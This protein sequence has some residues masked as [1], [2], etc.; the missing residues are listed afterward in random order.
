MRK[1]ITRL[2]SSAVLLSYLAVVIC[3][4]LTY[5]DAVKLRNAAS[6]LLGVFIGKVYAAEEDELYY[7]HTDHLGSTTV[8]TDKDGEVIQHTRNYPYGADRAIQEDSNAVTERK[9][10]GQIRDSSTSLYYYNARYYD[11]GLGTF[12]SADTQG[13]RYIYAGG[14]PV[15]NTD[16]TG[17]RADPG[18]GGGDS[19]VPYGYNAAW[20]EGLAGSM[21]PGDP[22][23]QYFDSL[24]PA[25]QEIYGEDS[26]KMFIL[27]LVVLGTAGVG[28]VAGPG[29]ALNVY[30]VGADISALTRSIKENNT[31]GVVLNSLA[32]G[33]DVIPLIGFG[34]NLA[35]FGS[36][37]PAEAELIKA[38]SK[39]GDDIV[40][41]AKEAGI[42]AIFQADTGLLEPGGGLAVISNNGDDFVVARLRSLANKGSNMHEIVHGFQVKIGMI[43]LAPTNVEL[44]FLD[45]LDALR[46]VAIN[47]V[48]RAADFEAYRQSDLLW[49][50]ISP[51]LLAPGATFRGIIDRKLNQAPANQPYTGPYDTYVPN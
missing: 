18:G 17:H 27:S 46:F 10:T 31:K 7:I 36:L 45:K 28:E 38:Q 48:A 24:T 37:F 39:H 12:I 5:A 13:E 50:I 19:S 26:R 35:K 25:E 42:D 2:I 15:M 51:I 1:K 14:N 43:D 34:K 21:S 32:L 30:G 23:Q 6:R 20:A 22:T 49:Q 40:K 33:L 11:P 8:I 47:P 4:P 29:V 44:S 3:S 9:F 16:P 41:L